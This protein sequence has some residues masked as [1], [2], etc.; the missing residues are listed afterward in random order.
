MISKRF[1]NSTGATENLKQGGFTGVKGIDVNGSILSTDTV[2]QTKN[3]DVN[4][5]GSLSLR[6]PVICV[7]EVPEVQSTEGNILSTELVCYKRI[8]DKDYV[9]VIRKDSENNQ[10]LGIFKDGTPQTIRLEWMSWQDYTSYYTNPAVYGANGFYKL[11]YLDLKNI[12]VSNTANSSVFTK[13]FVNIADDVFKREGV[14]YPDELSTDLFYSK[15]YDYKYGTD[16]T[17]VTEFKP[18]MLVLSKSTS[19]STNFDLKIVTPD[20]NTIQNADVIMLDTNLSLDNSYALRDMYDT[21]A[22]VV[23]SILP[24][25]PTAT[26]QGNTEVSLSNVYRESTTAHTVQSVSKSPAVEEFNPSKFTNGNISVTGT[27]T[28]SAKRRNLLVYIRPTACNESAPHYSNSMLIREYESVT[29]AT[30]QFQLAFEVRG[31]AGEYVFYVIHFGDNKIL[32]QE[33][34]LSDVHIS[35]AP[36]T[37]STV[38]SYADCDDKPV[39][40]LTQLSLTSRDNW[41]LEVLYNYRF[42]NATYIADTVTLEQINKIIN[43]CT[44][45]TVSEVEEACAKLVE[46]FR[47]VYGDYYYQSMPEIVSVKPCSLAYFKDWTT[48]QYHKLY[49][50]FSVNTHITYPIYDSELGEYAWENVI[51]RYNWRYHE[52]N[53]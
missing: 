6:K 20:I 5:D 15:L 52:P 22:P 27:L 2:L 38:P 25:I 12:S 36:V 40:Y 23:K 39:Q 44:L 7:A 29:D 13:V 32:S 42:Q 37:M 11:D 41:S 3:L 49:T 45:K 26:V 16:V 10:Y 43:I 33:T 17:V 28:D 35:Y 31:N 53:E 47:K 30:V 9:L 48:L 4:L 34:N 21:S 1:R 8:F 24:Y 46:D 50:Y 18:R 19:V 51:R 14:E